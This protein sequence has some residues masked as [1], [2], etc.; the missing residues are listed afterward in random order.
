MESDIKIAQETKELPIEE[1]AAKVDLK[2]KI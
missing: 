2:R 1:V